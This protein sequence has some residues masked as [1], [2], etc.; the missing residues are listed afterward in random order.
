MVV[1]IEKVFHFSGFPCVTDD[2]ST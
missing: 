1:C 2:G